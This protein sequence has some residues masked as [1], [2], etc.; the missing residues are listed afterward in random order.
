MRGRTP[1][2]ALGAGVV[3]LLA[4]FLLKAWQRGCVSQLTGE[5]AVND[6][7]IGL[8]GEAL[9]CAKLTAWLR[10]S[11]DIEH[12]QQVAAIEVVP[13]SERRWPQ[14]HSAKLNLSLASGAEDVEHIGGG[15]GERLLFLKKVLVTEAKLESLPALRRDLASNGNEVRFYEEFRDILSQRGLPLI[16]AIH[17]DSRLSF[18]DQNLDA[19]ATDEVALR[20]SGALFLLESAEGYYQASPLSAKQAKTTLKLLANFHAA[21]WEDEELLVRAAN[22]LHPLAGYWT[23]QQRGREE[24]GRMAENWKGYVAAFA[25]LRPELFARPGIAELAQRIERLAVWVS[26]ELST[27]PGQPFATLVHGD[28]KAMNIFLREDLKETE[29]QRF[30]PSPAYPSAESDALLIDF[31]W[32]GV[33]FGMSDVAMHLSHSVA[34]DALRDG[35][36]R[37]LVQGYHQELLAAIGTSRAAAYT[38]EIAW[39]HYCLAVVDYARMVLGCFFVNASP[40]VFAARA[41]QEN[42]GLCYRDVE[43]SFHFVERVDRS[44]RAIEE[45]ALSS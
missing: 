42:V 43:A 24:M 26:E 33:G 9:S 34:V 36:E 23:M 5:P 12:D 29:S 18:L 39:R 22:R 19:A 38:T 40:Q 8:D 13:G 1:R 3:V 2:V 31:Q 14:S 11:G 30:S 7:L 27:L 28:Y 20:G 41:Q 4:S 37:S 35:G 21:A 25:A 15:N 44:L 16:K 10:K 32:T 6:L 17:V 45:E